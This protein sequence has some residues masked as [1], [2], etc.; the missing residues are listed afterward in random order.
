M[1]ELIK[2]VTGLILLVIVLFLLTYQGWLKAFITLIQGGIISLLILIA[3]G[4]I[5]IGL[6]ELK[7][8]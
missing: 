8:E 5:L 4:L 3:L 1:N 6:S 2:V 7:D